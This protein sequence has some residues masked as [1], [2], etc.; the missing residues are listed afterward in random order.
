M[1]VDFIEEDMSMKAQKQKATGLTAFLMKKLGVS[2]KVASS[3]LLF[4]VVILILASGFV[5]AIDYIDFTAE[6]QRESGFDDVDLNRRHQE[7]VRLQNNIQ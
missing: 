5:F 3:L 7:T 6:L 1:A 4:L 2:K